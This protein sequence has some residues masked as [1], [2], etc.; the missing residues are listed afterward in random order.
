[1]KEIMQGQ[2]RL[3]EQCRGV[4]AGTLQPPVRLSYCEDCPWE[5]GQSA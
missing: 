2:K 5:A 3:G 4:Q 1:M